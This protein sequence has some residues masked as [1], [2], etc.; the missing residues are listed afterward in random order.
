MK[1]LQHHV[2]TKTENANVG[3]SFPIHDS[4]VDI[5]DSVNSDLVARHSDVTYDVNYD[6]ATRGMNGTDTDVP[7]EEM[8]EKTSPEKGVCSKGTLSNKD[9]VKASPRTQTAVRS[10]AV[11]RGGNDVTPPVAMRTRARSVKDLYGSSR[12]TRTSRRANDPP[13]D[14]RRSTRLVDKAHKQQ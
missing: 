11:E 12:A 1:L 14:V 7:I 3:E 13:G 9:P 2:L 6:A 10:K 5:P 8:T 4:E